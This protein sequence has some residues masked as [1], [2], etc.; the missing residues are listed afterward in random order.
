MEPG[1][2]KANVAITTNPHPLNKDIGVGLSGGS[3]ASLL[4]ISSFFQHE[5][6]QVSA[7]TKLQP[8][9]VDDYVP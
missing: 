7:V 2:I 5:K 1:L 9:S 3:S 8:L 6:M 4:L